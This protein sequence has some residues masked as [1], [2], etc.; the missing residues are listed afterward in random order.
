MRDGEHR[1]WMDTDG[2]LTEREAELV[3]RGMREGFQEEL[4]ARS[5]S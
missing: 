3:A 5:P 2:Y 1:K 4:A